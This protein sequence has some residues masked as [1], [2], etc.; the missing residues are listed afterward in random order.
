[1]LLASIFSN[2]ISSGFPVEVV[3]DAIALGIV[4]AVIPTKLDF[5]ISAFFLAFILKA[6]FITTFDVDKDLTKRS[7]L[8]LNLIDLLVLILCFIVVK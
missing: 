5:V 4:W 1:M 3:D 6:S 7:V 2:L 8:I